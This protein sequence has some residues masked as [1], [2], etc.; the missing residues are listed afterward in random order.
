MGLNSWVTFSSGVHRE[1][2]LTGQFL[3]LGDEVNPVLSA[4]LDNN[5]EITGLADSTLFA[6]PR[7]YTMDVTGIGTF[8]GLAT[9]VQRSLDEIRVVRKKNARKINNVSA[10]VFP[11][12]SAITGPPLDGVLAMRGVVT[13]GVY[14]AAIGRKALLHGDPIGREMGMTTWLSFA[15]TDD[16]ALSTGDMLATADELQNLLKALRMK[17]MSV[18][19]IRNHTFGEHPQVVFVRFWGEGAAVDLAKALRFVLEVQIGATSLK[20]G[21]E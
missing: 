3:L 17:G 10:P 19:S 12:A 21:H 11:R 15:G 18:A 14:R 2:I 7:L 8:Q 9:A 16:H 1:A 20:A 13:G 4:A 6:G 5:L